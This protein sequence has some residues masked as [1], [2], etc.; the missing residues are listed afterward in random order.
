MVKRQSV[1]A[2]YVPDVHT[3]ARLNHTATQA[4]PGRTTTRASTGSMT[5]MAGTFATAARPNSRQKTTRKPAN[6]G[7]I[8]RTTTNSTRTVARP[9]VVESFVP[10]PDVVIFDEFEVG[11]P[12][13]VTLNLINAGGA[14]NRVIVNQP[15]SKAL[16]IR[17]YVLSMPAPTARYVTNLV[18]DG[19][20]SAVVLNTA[21]GPL[22]V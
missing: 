15:K 13:K 4:Q 8:S 9:A 6:T 20:V 22:S 5:H 18:Y 10:S 16:L 21:H 1:P 14:A 12:V 7:T 2:V 19:S 11:V 17:R 3:T